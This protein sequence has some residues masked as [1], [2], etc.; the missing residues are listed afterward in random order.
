MAEPLSIGA[1]VEAVEKLFGKVGAAA[2][3]ATGAFFLL[4]SWM[5]ADVGIDQSDPALR[6][7]CGIILLLS[8]AACLV[9]LALSV[10]PLL[11]SLMD[12]LFTRISVERTYYKLSPGARMMLAVFELSGNR[13]MLADRSSDAAQD[14]IDAKLVYIASMS[15]DVV[16]LAK[17]I[18]GTRFIQSYRANFRTE[19]EKSPKLAKQIERDAERALSVYMGRI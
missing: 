19:I 3:L 5:L 13:E 7:V 16:S 2:A 4:P 15:N 8:V 1:I 14:L 6:H 10:W 9:S 18:A 12:L 11:F 17:S